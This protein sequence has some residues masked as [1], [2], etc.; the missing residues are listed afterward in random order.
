MVLHHLP[1]VIIVESVNLFNHYQD[2]GEGWWEAKNERGQRGLVPESYLEVY[3][4]GSGI[5]YGSYS[6]VLR[7]LFS[8]LTLAS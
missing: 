5:N 8:R 2:V 6:F 4:S 3:S 7:C 1:S